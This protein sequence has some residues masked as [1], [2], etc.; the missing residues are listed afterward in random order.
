M[1]AELRA[2][3]PSGSVGARLFDVVD[4]QYLNWRFSR[5]QL[6]PE[7]FLH[8]RQNVGKS[9]GTVVSRKGEIDSVAT[10]RRKTSRR[11]PG[12]APIG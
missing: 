2:Y 8:R 3:E 10:F 9:V 11:S 1:R 5:F 6:E 12:E 4:H 7:L